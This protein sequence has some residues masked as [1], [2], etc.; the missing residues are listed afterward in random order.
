LLVVVGRYIME[1]DP[2]LLAYD[3]PCWHRS[4]R[5]LWY[6]SFNWF[7]QLNLVFLYV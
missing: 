7:Y 3:A 4:F 5:N 6:Y 1:V 2:F